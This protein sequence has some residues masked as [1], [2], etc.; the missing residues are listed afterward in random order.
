MTKQSEN[1]RQSKDTLILFQIPIFNMY[2]SYSERDS[3][4]IPPKK[5]QTAGPGTYEHLHAL[6]PL[7]FQKHSIQ[8]T[9]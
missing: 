4:C 8:V 1:I 6:V 5:G 7:A 9:H 2:Q 3:F